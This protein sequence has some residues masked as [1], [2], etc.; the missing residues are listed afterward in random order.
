MLLISEWAQD[1]R[2]SD[3]RG[4]TLCVIYSI[5]Y[6]RLYIKYKLVDNCLCSMWHIAA[7]GDLDKVLNSITCKVL[8]NTC[9][10]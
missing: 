1:I 5:L 9:T 7:K 2:C 3:N 10:I 6:I 8:N 4:S